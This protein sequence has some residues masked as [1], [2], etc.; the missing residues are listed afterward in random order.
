MI[1]KIKIRLILLWIVLTLSGY[2]Y[3]APA[4]KLRVI[5]P[6]DEHPELEHIQYY[7]KLLA[8]SLEKTTATDGEFEI[9]LHPQI[10][11]YERYLQSVKTGAI[12]VIWTNTNNE[13]EIEFRP[14][15]IPI[16]KD[17]NSYR[18]FFIRKED[19][20]LFDTIKTVS[21]L[22]KL[23]AGQGSTWPDTTILRRN[24]FRVITAIRQDSLL[25]MLAS[26]RFDFYPR[27]LYEIWREKASIQDKNIVIE[28]NLMI[29]YDSPI[30]FFV[31]KNNVAL[32]SR[33][34]RGLRIAISDGSFDQ[35][36]FGV[37]NFKRGYEEQINSR[38]ILFRLEGILDKPIIHQ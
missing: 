20:P 5:V 24:D 14:I 28:K 34:E 6:P 17:L 18:I 13:R 7:Y 38:R 12:D 35:L 21:D 2:A 15:H 36:F 37:E 26:K 22:R 25:K 30:Y 29:Y 19:Q 1:E 31:N 27:G 8:L 11:N 16:L 9:V 10:S 3:A 4:E 33:I 32:A 23:T